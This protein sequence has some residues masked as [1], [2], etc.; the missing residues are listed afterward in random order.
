MKNAKLN[1]VID[2]IMLVNMMALIGVGLLNKYVLLT[3]QQKWEK[4]GENMEF[5]FW[6]FERH[7]WNRIHFILGLVLFGLLVLHIWLHWKMVIN[8]YNSLIKKKITRIIVAL[9]LLVVSIVLVVFPVFVDPVVDEPAFEGG[10]QY[11]EN[12]GRNEIERGTG[13]GEGR[14]RQSA[15]PLT[16]EENKDKSNYINPGDEKNE[17]SIDK[18][19]DH[20][21]HQ[22][23]GSNEGRRRDIPTYIDVIGSMTLI[24]VEEKYKVPANHI[25]SKL[26]IPMSISNNERLGRLKRVYGF[27]MSDIEEIIYNFQKAK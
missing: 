18:G 11:L 14:L 25:K 20:S 24:E 19:Q 2:A 17:L 8:I 21:S 3:G 6:G 9:S 22:N 23:E 4:Y 10:R 13:R 26:D 5:Y 27:T 15:E 12:Y 7:D 1:L 16:I